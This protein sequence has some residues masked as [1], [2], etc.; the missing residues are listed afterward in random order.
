MSGN[1]IIRN[2]DEFILL[3]EIYAAFTTFVLIIGDKCN[4]FHMN[5]VNAWNTRNPTFTASGSDVTVTI[6]VS[7]SDSGT[8]F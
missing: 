2:C 1:L 3:T 6:Q 4:F 7:Q 5:Y 8:T